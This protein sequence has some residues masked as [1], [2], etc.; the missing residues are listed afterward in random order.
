M[1]NN[2]NL[3]LVCQESQGVLE[4]NQPRGEMSFRVERYSVPSYEGNSEAVVVERQE[5]EIA[6]VGGF[7]LFSVELRS[8]NNLT[9]ANPFP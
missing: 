4:R 6:F 7:L 8:H 1:S 3:N 9:Q 2:L 5:D